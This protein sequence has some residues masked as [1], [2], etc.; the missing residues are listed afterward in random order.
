MWGSEVL[1]RLFCC[2][3]SSLWKWQGEG[4][5]RTSRSYPDHLYVILC[6]EVL[7][8]DWSQMSGHEWEEQGRQELLDTLLK[9]KNCSFRSQLEG[10]GLGPTQCVGWIVCGAEGT[11][12]GESLHI[13]PSLKLEVHI[14][15]VVLI[16]KVLS[17][18]APLGDLS[19][20]RIN[21]VCLH[22]ETAHT[23]PVLLV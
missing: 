2:I 13:K 11:G 14:C 1:V 9:E 20:S 15:L 12:G 5:R 16:L 22:A 7:K 19:H 3:R 23:Q 4:E 6:S 21:C 8:Q 17:C 18:F 10:N